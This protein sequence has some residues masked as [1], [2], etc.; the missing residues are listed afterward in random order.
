MTSRGCFSSQRKT[1]CTVSRAPAGR[2]CPVSSSRCMASCTGAPVAV[3]IGAKLAAVLLMTGCSSLRLG[4]LQLSRQIVDRGA[5]LL[6][7]PRGHVDTHEIHDVVM[8]HVL[9]P[10]SG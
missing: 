7:A 9:P 5:N 10:G 3:A 4:R 8:D 1:C 2:T 6:H